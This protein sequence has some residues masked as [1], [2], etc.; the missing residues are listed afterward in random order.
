[1]A[2][3]G[4]RLPSRKEWSL[5]AN[6]CFPAGYKNARTRERLW[7][8][9]CR[10]PR[11]PGQMEVHSSWESGG[12]GYNGEYALASVSDCSPECKAAGSHGSPVAMATWT[13]LP[14]NTSCPLCCQED[15]KE[16]V[17]F[18]CGKETCLD[19][20]RKLVQSCP[21]A[22]VL[23]STLEIF[24][25]ANN[26]EHCHTCPFCKVS[27]YPW[28]KVRHRTV[29]SSGVASTLEVEVRSLVP[30]PY[31]Y[32]SFSKSRASHLATSEEF[33]EMSRLYDVFRAK[34][35]AEATRESASSIEDV[36]SFADAISDEDFG[37]LHLLKQSDHFRCHPHE[38]LNFLDAVEALHDRHLDSGFLQRVADA[39]G[40]Q[41][42]AHLMSNAYSLG[43]NRRPHELHDS[44]IVNLLERKGLLE[45]INLVSE[46]EGYDSRTGIVMYDSENDNEMESV[47]V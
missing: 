47:N 5:L 4:K 2:L 9:S 32:Q 38:V 40:T 6:A 45:V 27:Y 33:P 13:A 24:D 11:C 41:E 23:H 25:P 1:M 7:R 39:N 29:N 36:F 3:E 42:R 15:L 16:W 18:P 22:I 26:K 28:T 44:L 14:E 8:I 19:C 21:A 20:L 12:F 46:S 31:A 35:L 30:V 34:K 37:R 17:L 10:R 43:W